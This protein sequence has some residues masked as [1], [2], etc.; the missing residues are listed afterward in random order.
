MSKD[1][2]LEIER[3]FLI[4][5]PDTAMLEGIKGARKI[6]ITQTYTE[7]GAR[8][9][10]WQEGDRVSYIKTVKTHITDLTRIE[11][12]NEIT[13]DEYEILLKEETSRLKK[14]RYRIPFEGHLLEIDIF[15]F[16]KNQAFLEIELQSEEETFS[17]P[18]YITVIKEVTEDKAYRNYALSK[19]IPKEEIF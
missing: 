10:R 5:Y 9:R 14:T 7:G 15:P 1:K 6:D 12:E 18:E 13:K 3:K 4:K 19:K 17:I 8:L 11:L 16:W 2:N